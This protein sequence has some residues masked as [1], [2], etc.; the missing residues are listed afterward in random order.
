[1][2]YTIYCIRSD[3]DLPSSLKLLLAPPLAPSPRIY[4]WREAEPAKKREKRKEK[5]RRTG[6]GGEPSDDG[7]GS[8]EEKKASAAIG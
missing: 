7:S 4:R 1:V 8:S 3:L 6:T 2:K 5:A